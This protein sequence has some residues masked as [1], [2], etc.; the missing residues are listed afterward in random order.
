MSATKQTEL[1]KAYEKG[2]NCGRKGDVAG[3][4]NPYL[5]DS[6]DIKHMFE[7]GIQVGYG[8]YLRNLG[9]QELMTL[10]HT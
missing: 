7:Q 9:T 1:D 8:Q 3:R 6:D 4:D 10:I 2:Y 5:G